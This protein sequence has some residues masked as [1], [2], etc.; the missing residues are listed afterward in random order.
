MSSLKHVLKTRTYRERSQPAAR[1]RLGLLEKHKDY[2]LRA[3][4]YHR[5]QNALNVLR[6]KA[7]FKNPDE[8][9]FGMV[10]T[11]IKDGVHQKKG[12]SQPTEEELIAFN[13][14]DAGYVGSKLAAEAKKVAR[15]QA[16]LHG[17]DQLQKPQNKRIIFVDSEAG[18]GETASATR[19]QATTRNKSGKAAGAKISAG[20]A[21]GF[22]EP[23]PRSKADEKHLKKQYAELKARTA[24]KEKLERCMQ[25]LAKQKAL[26][27]KGRR[28]KLRSDNGSARQ[29]KW[30]QE[31]SK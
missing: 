1:K 17:L 2:K 30:R 11:K 3:R 28:K 6:E 10:H 14:E 4:D 31:R 18:D 16:S 19:S 9:Y 12:G 24:R 29:Y 27:G 5:K 22:A 25:R 23:A 15:L 8:F 7:A 26:K 20:S 21:S 13:R